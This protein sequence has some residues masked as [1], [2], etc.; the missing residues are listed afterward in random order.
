MH[1]AYLER[2][3][4]D[5]VDFP[6]Y[7]CWNLSKQGMFFLEIGGLVYLSCSRCPLILQGHTEIASLQMSNVI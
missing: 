2:R 3:H 6:L 5:E 4:I 7:Y 1:A